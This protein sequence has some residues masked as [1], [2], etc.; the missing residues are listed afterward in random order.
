MNWN[1]F[2]VCMVVLVLVICGLD[3]SFARGEPPATPVG[4]ENREPRYF[5]WHLEERVPLTLDLT[6]IVLL[7]EGDVPDHSPTREA[8]EAWA[9][10]KQVPW[11]LD[12][13][14]GMAPQ[15]IQPHDEIRM[16]VADLSA[17]HLTAEGI[18]AL[19]A[20]LSKDPMIEFAGP[21]FSTDL[22]PSFLTRYIMLNSHEGILSTDVAE[23]VKRLEVG[24]IVSQEY[25]GM[26]RHFRIRS[27]SKNGFE[28]LRAANSLHT[29]DIVRFAE[30]DWYVSGRTELIPNDPGFGLQWGLHNTG[31]SG[32]FTDVDIDAPEAWDV[33]VTGRSSTVLILDDGVQVNHPDLNYD[34][35]FGKNFTSFPPDGDGSPVSPNDRHG[36]AVAGVVAARTNNALGV[37]GVG[38]GVFL[39][40]AKIYNPNASGG[41]TPNVQSIAAGI[42][43]SLDVGAQVTNSSFSLGQSSQTISFAYED[44]WNAGVVHFAASG[45]GAA[46]FVSYPA[47]LPWVAAV[48]AI[49]R[50]GLRADFS[51]TGF[52]LD[53]VGPGVDI[54]TTDR[55]G[56]AGYNCGSNPDYVI[57][58][59]GSGTDGT[60]FASPYAAGVAA[61]LLRRNPRLTPQQVISRMQQTCVDISPQV[62]GFGF[63]EFTG[64]GLISAAA[65]LGGTAM[66]RTGDA[67]GDN[68][69]NFADITAV[70]TN[71][72]TTN[73]D[74]DADYNGTVVFADIT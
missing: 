2:R 18:E 47:S 46:P 24:E 33:A 51:N 32:G 70:L 73:L 21:V 7:R 56:C 52:D 9:R 62:Y 1:A 38:L 37:A 69:A 6:R 45:N 28:V 57:S 27:Y 30:P 40:S 67:N 41:F 16:W 29:Q 35:R 55:T 72:G 31:Q 68:A 34:T 61:L 11:A 13:R 4:E 5:R 25:L 60:S 23:L 58:P 63:D 66:P 20:E 26:P 39:V 10:A 53:F 14:H 42:M 19:V 50:T 8:I 59:D 22:G 74:G 65:A 36:T 64:Y 49:D 54:Y 17:K 15:S 3:S 48:G 44:T 71:F 12:A 43:Y